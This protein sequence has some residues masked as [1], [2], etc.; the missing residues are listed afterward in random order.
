MVFSCLAP[1]KSKQNPNLDFEELAADTAQYDSLHF[2]YSINGDYSGEPFLTWESNQPLPNDVK[3]PVS[4]GE[5]TIQVVGYAKDGSITQRI[6]LFTRDKVS[7]QDSL[8]VIKTP[9]TNQV[10][11]DTISEPPPVN[12]DS[13]KVDVTSSSGGNVIVSPSKFPVP[14]GTQIILIAKPE[15]GYSFSGW[16]GDT[17]GTETSLVFNLMRNMEDI[18]ASFIKTSYQGK[19]SITGKGEIKFLHI[20]DSNSIPENVSDSLTTTFQ[21]GEEIEIQANP[22]EGQEFVGWSGDTSS[23]EQKISFTIT[24]SFELKAIFKTIGT[25]V[26]SATASPIKGGKVDVTPKKNEYQK[27]N[28]EKAKDHFITTINKAKDQYG[29]EAQYLLAKIQYEQEKYDSSLETLFDLNDKFNN[30][31]QWVGKSFLLIAE[32]YIAKDEI[33]QAKA[34]LNSLIDN[35]PMES[36]K[37]KAKKKL[38]ELKNKEQK[39]QQSVDTVDAE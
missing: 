17:S 31:D 22:E 36:I 15:P 18:Q 5:Y 8:H 20:S 30:Y 19:F 32:N 34:T 13:L 21:H 27:G 11:E 9:D 29:A 35:H 1:E 6:L 39:K 25:Y 14:K 12:I 33:F 10:P 24:N 23:T 4:E 2:F 16:S 28:L 37:E 38:K 26:V 7:I 3:A